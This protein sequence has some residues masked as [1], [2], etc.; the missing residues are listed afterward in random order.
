MAAELDV[1]LISPPVVVDMLL[2]LNSSASSFLF[3]ETRRRD[4]EICENEDRAA[5]AL[6]RYLGE[7]RM[8]REGSMCVP[9]GEASG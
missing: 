8:A 7:R 3:R 4:E 5:P 6:W 1:G 2:A 9:D